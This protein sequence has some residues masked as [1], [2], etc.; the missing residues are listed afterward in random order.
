MT[1][2]GAL[3]HYLPFPSS[4]AL[5][6]NLHFSGIHNL[7]GTW[8]AHP[9]WTLSSKR[10]SRGCTSCSSSGD[11]G[12]VLLCNNPV[13]SLLVHRCMVWISRQTGQEQTTTDSQDCKRIIAADLP[14]IHDLYKARA[15]K[16]AGNITADPSQLRHN[17]FQL[18]PLVGATEHCTPKQ[19]GICAVSF[20]RTS[21]YWTLKSVTQCQYIKPLL[22]LYQN[23]LYVLFWFCCTHL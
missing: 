21:L 22:L 20:H 10:P 2:G 3:L 13:C 9:V 14:L 19:A 15:M 17:L 16:L 11:V 12:P 1:S 4:A 7:P 23:M 5:L 18:F 6:W 8:S